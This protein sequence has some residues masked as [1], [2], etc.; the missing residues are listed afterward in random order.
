MLGQASGLRMQ[1]DYQIIIG[2]GNRKWEGECL[3]VLV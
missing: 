1:V 2:Q 3:L